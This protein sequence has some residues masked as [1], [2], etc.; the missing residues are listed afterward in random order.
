MAQMLEQATQALSGLSHCAGVVLAPKTDNSLKHVE[1]VSLGPGR[2]LV[3][4][5]G[6]GGLVENRV[7]ELP[8]GIPPAA[9]VQASNFLSARLMG[10][11]LAEAR[12]EV[13]RELEENRAELDELAKKV[14]QAGLA[15]WSGDGRDEGYLIVRGQSKLLED[16]TAIEELE[17]I[18]L[19]F[20]TLETKE[21]MIRL[22]DAAQGGEGVQIFIG[23]ENELFGM[24]GCSM[25]IAPYSNSQEQIVGAIGVIGPTRLNYARVIPMVD[26]TAKVIG[27]LI[28]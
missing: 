20:E 14:V 3:V 21:T 8:P 7:V 19:L 12:S 15:T 1:F 25:V 5:V 6:A 16:V 17:R 2:A 26:Y 18:R 22:L 4:M 24:T 27:R 23:R 28:G 9:L 13:F 11:T 10:R